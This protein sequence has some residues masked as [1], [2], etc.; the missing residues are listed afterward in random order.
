MDWKFTRQ[1]L[2]IAFPMSVQFSIIALSSIVIQSVCNSFG[3]VTIAAFTSAMRIEQLASQPMVSFGI[4]MATY[5]A[6]N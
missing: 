6:Q 4:A 1:H 5:T 3:P 2:A